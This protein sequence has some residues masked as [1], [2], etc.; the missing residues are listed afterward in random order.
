MLLSRW[1][2][3]VLVSAPRG[4]VCIYTSSSPAPGASLFPCATASV[5]AGRAVSSAVNKDLDALMDVGS[6]A[7]ARDDGISR[8]LRHDCVFSV[9]RGPAPFCVLPSLLSELLLFFLLLFAE[10]VCDGLTGPT[11]G[12]AGWNPPAAHTSA[13]S[14]AQP[15]PQARIHHPVAGP[16]TTLQG[17]ANR[18]GQWTLVCTRPGAK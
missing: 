17:S 16:R 13:D 6:L 18:T 12:P 14:G 9:P 10:S 11:F 3:V 2:V 15:W 4:R 7:V 8:P 5:T 1:I